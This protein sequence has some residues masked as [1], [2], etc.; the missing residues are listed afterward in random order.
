MPRCPARLQ[1]LHA[2]LVG[3]RPGNSPTSIAASSSTSRHEEVA[4]D[5]SGPNRGMRILERL[6]TDDDL[7]AQERD[8]RD[9]NVCVDCSGFG[10]EAHEQVA[11]PANVRLRAIELAAIEMEKTSVESEPGL[12]DLITVA[13]EQSQGPRGVAA[14]PTVKVG[15]GGVRLPVNLNPLHL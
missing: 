2:G 12:P 7:S 9:H 13:L 10:A 3:P 6:E 15:I 4:L 8:L 5:A 11:C 14:D 1:E